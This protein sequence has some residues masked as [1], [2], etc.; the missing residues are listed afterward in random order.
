MRGTVHSRC[1]GG[2]SSGEAGESFVSLALLCLAEAD[3]G[4]CVFHPILMGLGM[5]RAT[6]ACAAIV[7]VVGDLEFCSTCRARPAAGRHRRD[8]ANDASRLAGVRTQFSHPC[9]SPALETASTRGRLSHRSGKHRRVRTARRAWSAS[10]PRPPGA[11]RR[12]SIAID[13]INR[14]DDLSRRA[15]GSRPRARGA[16]GRGPRVATCPTALTPMAI[17]YSAGVGLQ[18][19]L[20]PSLISIPESIKCLRRSF[21]CPAVLDLYGHTPPDKKPVMVVPP[22]NSSNGRKHRRGPPT[23]GGWRPRSASPTCGRRCQS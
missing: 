23:C 15:A 18:V 11:R 10:S 17:W 8:A 13:A 20:K 16:R 21:Q 9:A 6:R 7:Q 22:A 3:Y 1:G 4:R 19:I 2:G 12:G 5:L 14:V